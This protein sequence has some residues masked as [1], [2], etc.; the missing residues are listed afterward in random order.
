MGGPKITFRPGRVDAKSADESV[1]DGRLPNATKK[2]D[3]LREVFH[4]MGFTDRDIVALSGAH[5]VGKAH[6]ERSGFEGPWTSNPYKFDN[7]FFVELLKGYWTQ[8]P[9]TQQFE[10][11]TKKLMMLPSDLALIED[12]GFRPIVEEYAKDQSSFFKDFA[13]AFQKL[14]EL[15]W[16]GKLGDP[17]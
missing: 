11:P 5:T 13:A 14:T 6:P 7:D 1:P 9:G 15:G 4:R 3:H 17:Q 16:E 10:D 8:K 2:A 12:P